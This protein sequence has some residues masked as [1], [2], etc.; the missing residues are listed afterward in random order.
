MD[1]KVVNPDPEDDESDCDGCD[2]CNKG[3]IENPTADEALPAAEGGV[4]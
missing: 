2:G 1:E 4:A 3:A